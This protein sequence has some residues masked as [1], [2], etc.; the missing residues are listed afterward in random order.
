MSSV[1]QRTIKPISG[2]RGGDKKKIKGKTKK[3]RGN[4]YEPS[5]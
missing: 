1:L 4:F 5:Q 3:Q 2:T